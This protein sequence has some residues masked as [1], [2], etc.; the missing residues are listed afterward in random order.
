MGA[1]LLKTGF[2][3]SME[4][5]HPFLSL[6]LGQ[7]CYA[8]SSLTFKGSTFPPRKKGVPS[9]WRGPQNGA[10]PIRLEKFR[11]KYG[12]SPECLGLG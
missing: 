11:N 5:Q 9:E 7:G 3:A 6:C 10:E 4:N 12:H 1:E 2:S 8:F